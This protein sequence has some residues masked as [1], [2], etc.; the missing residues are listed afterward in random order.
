MFVFNIFF[1][2]ASTAMMLTPPLLLARLWHQLT[3]K[4][5]ELVN[6]PS[7]SEMDGMALYTDFIAHFE[8]KFNQVIFL[9]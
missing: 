9:L 6:D 8:T 1:S 2:W 4:L 7:F 3:L 5:F